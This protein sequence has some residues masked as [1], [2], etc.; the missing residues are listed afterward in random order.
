M[1]INLKESIYSNDNS[2][3]LENMTLSYYKKPWIYEAN[4]LW[5][6]AMHVQVL[7]CNEE[8]ER[9]GLEQPQ[10]KKSHQITIKRA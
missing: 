10:E 6:I 9:R 1:K 3:V 7:C 4:V 8:T 2:N 5:V